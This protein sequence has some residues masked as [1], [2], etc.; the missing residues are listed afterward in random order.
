[1]EWI[2]SRQNSAI[3]PDRNEAVKGI[4]QNSPA[5]KKLVSISFLYLHVLSVII[6]NNTGYFRPLYPGGSH[7]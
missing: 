6:V 7:I 1:M 5:Q 3:T 4:W 2:V